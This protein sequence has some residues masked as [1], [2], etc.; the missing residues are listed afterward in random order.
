MIVTIYKNIESVKTGFYRKADYVFD[1]IQTGRSKKLIEKIRQ[2]PEKEKRDKLKEGLPSICF[3]GKFN[4]RS[5]DG[6]T[7]HSGLIC[8]DFDKIPTKDEV[9]DLKAEICTDE[10]VFACFISP[11]GMGLKVIVKIPPNKKTHVGSF[12]ALEKRFDSEYFDS[13]TGN[14]SRVCYESYDPDIYVN[15]DSLIFTEIE[16]FEAREDIGTETP[17]LKLE[18]DNQII[19]RLFVWF[20]KNYR[21][22]KG[23]RNN[24]L[25]IL[26]AAFNTF[27]ISKSEAERTLLTYA[28]RDFS[29]RE[30]NNIVKSAYKNTADHGTRFFEDNFRAEKIE[31]QIRQGK[32]EREIISKNSDIKSTDLKEFISE[33][34][35]N[36]EI[37][38]F[39]T[40]EKNGECKL[41]P[42]KYKQFLEQNGFYKFYPKGSENFIFIKIRE[43]KVDNTS[44]EEIKDFV[45]DYLYNGD[46]GIKPY[47]YMAAS[48]KYFKDDFLSLLDT[49]EVNFKEDTQDKAYLYFNNCILEISESEINVIDYLDL[50]GYVWDKHI[51]NSD[52][53][54]TQSESVFSKF[55]KNV[56]GSEENEKTLKS[57]IGYLLHSYKNSGNNKSI[58][59]NDSVI[60]EVPNG[61]SGKG[62]ICNAINKVKRTA[63][64]DGKQF[65]FNKSFLYQTVTVDTQVL[66]F[67]DV[68][69]NFQFENLFSLITE[70]ITIEKKNKDAIKIPIE[71]SPKIVIT[72]NYTIKAIGGSF[73]R[74]KFEIELSSHYN[75]N[76]T[77]FNDFNHM[78]FDDWDK[79]EYAKFYSYMIHCIQFY[80]KNGL[81]STNYENLDKRKFI[82]STSYEFYEWTQEETELL[83][84][85]NRIY[86][87]PVFN[88]F[89]E[90]YPDFKKW[91]SQKKFA[92][93]IE[94]Y[95]KEMGYEVEKGKSIEGR[96]TIFYSDEDE[97]HEQLPF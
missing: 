63:F 65:D 73:E 26:A 46:F 82:N 90:E 9:F 78:L 28:E 62:L 42:H 18:S 77:P 41:K 88:S 60:S 83:K 16:D 50:D 45:L 71:N 66:V 47:D 87:T 15:Y 59:F 39:W 2:E 72:T 13:G 29:E 12:R 79:I 7:Q 54:N 81:V 17:K 96:Y 6:I 52:Y 67:D 3:A 4:Y 85:G 89:I 84:P 24:N 38:E 34:K 43:N 56:G 91:L 5:N 37:T 11:S 92:L 64:L 10:Y 32:S 33:T 76:H 68:K 8:L 14:I 30:I 1:R 40:Y 53:I 49:K 61:G 48:T 75:V 93:W 44:S 36:F 94:T 97:I 25:F 57:V 20:N 31:R 86:R 58:I 80:L 27:G 22:T 69:R 70:G 51:I 95:G 23:Q 35:E 19:Q 55:I 21:V 74:R